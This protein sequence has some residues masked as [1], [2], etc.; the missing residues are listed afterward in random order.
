M[1]LNAAFVQPWSLK[2]GRVA[3]FWQISNHHLDKSDENN[4]SVSKYQLKISEQFLENL[5]GYFDAFYQN[6]L[7]HKKTV[8]LKL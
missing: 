4:G 1:Y 7:V 8:N 3:S 6:K 2:K 5:I